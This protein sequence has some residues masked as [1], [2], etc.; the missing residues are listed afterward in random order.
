MPSTVPSFGPRQFSALQIISIETTSNET[1][2]NE[3]IVEFE[4]AAQQFITENLLP[5]EYYSIDISSVDVLGQEYSTPQRRLQTSSE[6]RVGMNVIGDVFPGNPPDSFSFSDVVGHG[7]ETN[8]TGFTNLLRGSS[9]FFREEL[10]PTGIQDTDPH[11]SGSSSKATSA[12]IYV[13]IAAAAVGV[14]ITAFAIWKKTRRPRSA[15][16]ESQVWSAESLDSISTNNVESLSPSLQTPERKYGTDSFGDII[17]QT[18]PNSMEYGKDRAFNN[19]SFNDESFTYSTSLADALPS[20]TLSVSSFRHQDA[21]LP[22]S[23]VLLLFPSSQCFRSL[24]CNNSQPMRKSMQQQ[25]KAL[26][27][28]IFTNNCIP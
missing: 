2:D 27:N 21:V 14:L 3:T 5:D 9:S 19:N 4:A 13:A 17:Y 18:S 26:Q 11:D 10:P 28:K 6:L 25:T 15:I 8:F 12:A 1:M 16:S 22:I 7:F 20:A 24:R 23:S